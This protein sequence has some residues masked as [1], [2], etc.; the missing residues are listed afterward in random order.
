MVTDVA[1]DHDSKNYKST[2]GDFG[3]PHCSYF[4]PYSDSVRRGGQYSYSKRPSIA[5][6]PTGPQVPANRLDQ[7]SAL[8]RFKQHS[9]SPLGSRQDILN[10]FIT[11]YA[12]F[13]FSRI[14]GAWVDAECHSCQAAAAAGLERPP[15]SGDRWLRTVDPNRLL[16]SWC[17]AAVAAART[18]NQFRCVFL[19]ADSVAT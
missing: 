10:W 5:I 3:A 16:P 4:F 15:P 12:E 11:G 19:V 2:C 13:C 8:P 1:G 14:C 18:K 9:D 17:E 7:R 6:G